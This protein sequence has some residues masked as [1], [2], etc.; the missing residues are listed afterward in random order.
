MSIFDVLKSTAKVLQEAGKIE[1]YQQ[2]LETMEK[3]LEMQNKIIELESENKDLKEKLSIKENLI[4][5]NNSYWIN[6]E[7]KKNGPF[8]SR[9]WDKNQELIRIHSMGNSALCRC[10]ECKNHF[11]IGPDYSRGYTIER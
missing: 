6:D 5:E 9:C 1:Q 7:G 10:P 2:I 11:Q 3:L 4:Y 8:C